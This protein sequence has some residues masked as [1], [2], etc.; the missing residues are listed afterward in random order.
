[1]RLA[2]DSYVLVTDGRKSLFLRNE[3]GSD[4]LSLKLISRRDN[5]NPA[6]HDQKSDAPGHAFSSAAG[7]SRRSALDEVDLHQRSEDAFALKAAELLHQEV[8]A[9]IKG[10]IVVIAPPKTLGVMRKH[11]HDDVRRRIIGELAK[12]LVKHPVVEIE[13]IIADS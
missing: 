10:G 6:D 11:Y 9:G 8:R 5:P 7:D 13:R 3:G 12:D 1:M 2:H 4:S